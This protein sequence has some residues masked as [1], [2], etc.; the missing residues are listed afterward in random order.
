VSISF[1]NQNKNYQLAQQ[2]WDNVIGSSS[3]VS[4]VLS[5]ALTNQAAGLAAISNHKALTRVTAQL[6][7]AAVSAAKSLTPAQVA[8]LSATSSS[9]KT[10]QATSSAGTSLNLLA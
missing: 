2:Q 5:N 10:T 7:A 4:S 1:Y 9:L 8:Q 3:A 6:K